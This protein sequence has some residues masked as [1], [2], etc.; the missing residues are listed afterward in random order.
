MRAA[1]IAFFMTLSVLC[2]PGASAQNLGDEA[3]QDWQTASFN[4]A[5][6]ELA[7]E[8]L[9]IGA[10]HLSC[11]DCD[12]CACYP[13]ECPTPPAPCQ[14]CPHV[15]TVLPYWNVN[16][17]GTL[18]ANMLFNTARPVAPGL[19]MFLAP[20]VAQPE[21]TVDIHAR[22]SSLG[23]LFTGPDVGNFKSGGLMLALFYNDALI[24]DRYGFLP[25]QAFGEL[26]NEDWRFA[27]GLQFNV[28]N[29]NLPTMLT[30][31]A[32]IASGDAGNNFPGQF[33]IERYF[34]PSDESDW[35]L[36]FA[37]SDPI[38]TG[39]VSQTPIS[40]IITGAPP[41]RITEDNGWPMLEGRLAYSLGEKKQEGLEAK[42]ELELGISAAGTQ[43]RTAVPFNP[44]VVANMYALGTDWRWRVTDR[45]GFLG[46]AFVGESMGFING[47]VLQNTNSADFTGIR[48]RGAWGE[49]YY[50][51]TPCLHTHLG[52]GI[53]NPLD[54][55]LAGA[56]I[57]RNRTAFSNVIWDVTR[58]FRLGLEVTWRETNY[59]LLPDNEGYGLQTQA[60]WAF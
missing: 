31:S 3:P 18:Q 8:S 60:Q 32:L 44:N 20:G 52:A 12:Q 16:I 24:V 58:Q 38:A 36:Q 10:A 45:F 2:T 6:T 49:V 29:P 50:Y 37:L 19:P 47:G 27:A 21:N 35:T 43:F 55:D 48:T 17:F 42:R 28:F 53:D 40:S 33:R 54:E 56:Q 7:S 46:E 15:S 59:R 41:L 23:A 14:P 51:L 1:S 34:H 25:I 13:C 11:P 22:S 26:K 39:V 5:S 57:Q 9:G 4:A 30:F